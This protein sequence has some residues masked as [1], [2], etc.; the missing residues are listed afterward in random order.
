M[1]ASQNKH[2]IEYELSDKSDSKSSSDQGEPN[3]K[4]QQHKNSVAIRTATQNK[5]N[6]KGMLIISSE[7][8]EENDQTAQNLINMKFKK[9][10]E[11]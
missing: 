3:K 10:K 8:E 1:E 6:Q 5:A 2:G 11:S 9:T 4:N 7:S